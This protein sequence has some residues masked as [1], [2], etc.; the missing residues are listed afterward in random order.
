[1]TS[2]HLSP[3]ALVT[4]GASGMGAAIARRLADDGNRV[5]VADL[6]EAGARDVVG[7]LAGE[8][9]A[10]G[11]DVADPHHLSLDRSEIK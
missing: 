2:A 1:M 9:V 6:D 8:A 3:V 7:S 5:V 10:G 11:S 4:G